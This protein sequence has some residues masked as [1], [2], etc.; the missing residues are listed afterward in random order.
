MKEHIIIREAQKT[1]LPLLL[2]CE[3]GVIAAERPFD[4]TIRNGA[5]T[6]Y[7]LLD[8]MENSRAIVLV[9]CDEDK[10]VATGYALEK[11]AKH[12]LDHEV[13]AYLGFMYTDPE[14]RGQGI[15][16]AI[17]DRL[18]KWSLSKGLTELRLTVYNDNEHAIRAYEKVGFK[19]HMIE[20]RLRIEK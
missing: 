2:Q 5:I 8:L 17:M 11:P 14:Y 20:M 1:D 15:N 9:A 10:V 7:D 4:P 18:K 19:K 16:G 3:Q 12:Y 6:Y 13:Y